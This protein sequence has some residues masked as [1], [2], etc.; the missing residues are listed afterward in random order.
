MQGKLDEAIRHFETHLVEE[1]DSPEVLDILTHLKSGA[2]PTL[3]FSPGPG[4]DRA[5]SSEAAGFSPDIPGLP[6]ARKEY[7]FPSALGTYDVNSWVQGYYQNPRP[8][9]VP[10]ILLQLRGG[11][12]LRIEEFGFQTLGLLA[13]LFAGHPDRVPVWVPDLH[14]YEDEDLAVMLRALWLSGTPSGRAL[15]DRVGE[16]RIRRIVPHVLQ[17]PPPRSKPVSAMMVGPGVLDYHW[18]RF[19]VSGD[20]ASVREVIDHLP[21]LEEFAVLSKSRDVHSEAYKRAYIGV[22]AYWSLGAN[23]KRHPLVREALGEEVPRRPKE[24][25]ETLARILQSLD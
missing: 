18:S 1:G 11:G 16:E 22:S 24:V 2:Q 7:T 9:E 6:D 23:A 10:E 13:E 14:T 20:K 19:F 17:A 12:I 21:G 8:G 15:L 3:H 4:T 25:R 5:Q